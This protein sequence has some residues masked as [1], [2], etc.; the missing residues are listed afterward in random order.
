MKRRE[1]V[2]KSA[3]IVSGC[4]VF[5]N[6]ALAGDQ[7]LIDE[8]VDKILNGTVEAREAALTELEGDYFSREIK[9]GVVKKVA[10]KF[11]DQRKQ[12]D[13]E[14]PS[15]GDKLRFIGGD[16]KKKIDIVSS[17]GELDIPEAKYFSLKNAAL[18]LNFFTNVGF[19]NAIVD[20]YLIGGY[21]VVREL[22]QSDKVSVKDIVEY[23][24]SQTFEPAFHGE[25]AAILFFL[26]IYKMYRSGLPLNEGKQYLYDHLRD[27][28]DETSY[29][30]PA[31]VSLVKKVVSYCKDE[32]I[33]ER[34]VFSPSAVMT[35]APW[36][37]TSE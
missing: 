20:G 24:R 21:P 37:P 11:D 23:I 9:T 15:R 26:A 29:G 33:D 17:F 12:Y 25:D 13:N 16:I 19:V 22:A 6:N 35:R 3:L 4:V 18:N 5:S 32:S 30:N 10:Q 28:K 36:D 27:W 7:E 34:S 2:G 31:R 8:C 1:F 14:F